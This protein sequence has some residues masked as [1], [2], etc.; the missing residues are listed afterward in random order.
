MWSVL[1]RVRDFSSDVRTESVPWSRPGSLVVIKT[2]SLGRPESL[3]A[4][5]I[6]DSLL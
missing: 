3:M 1:R 6:P 4:L 2:S 5:P